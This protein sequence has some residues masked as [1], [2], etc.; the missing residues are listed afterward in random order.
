MSRVSKPAL[1]AALLAVVSLLADGSAWAQCSMCRTALESQGPHATGVVNLAIIVLLFPAVALF[2]GVYLVAFRNAN[3][4]ES[5]VEHE[6]V[7]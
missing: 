2:T 4:V 1:I 5:E 6:E 7:R 3:P